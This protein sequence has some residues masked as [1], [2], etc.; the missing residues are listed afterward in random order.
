MKKSLLGVVVGVATILSISAPVFAQSVTST[1]STSTQT[2][3]TSTGTSF[4]ASPDGMIW[5]WD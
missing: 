2:T 5:I 4:H 3:T 1:S